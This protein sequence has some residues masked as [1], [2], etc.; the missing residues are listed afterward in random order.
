MFPSVPVSPKTEGI[1]FS[2][3]SELLVM[4]LMRMIC[5]DLIL[6]NVNPYIDLPWL[7][8]VMYTDSIWGILKLLKLDTWP[9]SLWTS[10]IIQQKRLLEINK[11]GVKVQATRKNNMVL[12]SVIPL[13]TMRCLILRSQLK[14]SHHQVSGWVD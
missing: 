10:Y 6:A 4:C 2:W 12:A 5:G 1:G 14:T 13:T 9:S 8:N 3:P 7:L 11:E